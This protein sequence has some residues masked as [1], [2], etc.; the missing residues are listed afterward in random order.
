[1]PDPRNTNDRIKWFLTHMP[2]INGDGRYDSGACANHSWKS[3][4]GDYGNPPAWG[5]RNANQLYDKVRNSGRYWTT[6]PKRGALILYRYGRNGHAAIVYDDAGTQIA[7]TDPSNGKWTGVEPIDFPKKWGAV[8][9]AVIW[10]DQY[11]GVRFSVGESSMSHGDVYLSKL[12]Y[13]QQDSDSV[14]RLQMHLNDHPLTGGETLP[15]TG[16]Y[17][18]QTDEEVR[19]CQT[20]H[21]YGNDPV[22]GSSVGPKQAAHL[23]TG[24]CGCAVINDL[25]TDGGGDE[26]QGGAVAGAVWDYYSGKPTGRLMITAEAGY[27]PVD[28]TVKPAPGDGLE[29]H[30]L[31]INLDLTWNGSKDGTIRVKYVRDGGDATAYQDYTAANGKGDFLI[32]AQHWESGQKGIGGRWYVDV[33]GGISRAVGG[34]RYVKSGGVLYK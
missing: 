22:N 3:L 27:V 6:I 12:V 7:T 25:P 30:M 16:N 2:D 4:G 23:F 26:T 15:I 31:Y 21:G 1:M 5:C 29:F 14:K 13:G 32:T 33:G 18:E 20:Q 17:G 24:S 9:S 11:N 19:L 8:S 34:T 28:A 10:T